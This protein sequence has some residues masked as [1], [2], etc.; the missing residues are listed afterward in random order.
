MEGSAAMTAV[1]LSPMASMARHE[2]GITRE[3]EPFESDVMGCSGGRPTPPAA[4]LR[5]DHGLGAADDERLV[6]LEEVDDHLR[7]GLRPL[8]AEGVA[9][10]VEEDEVGVGQELLVDAPHCR[11]DDG[12]ER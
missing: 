8:R 9:R 5:M 6:P 11:R 2:A 7:E 3:R 12:V 4:R 10:V 1:L